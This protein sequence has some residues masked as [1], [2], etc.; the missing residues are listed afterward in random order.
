MQGATVF[1]LAPDARNLDRAR[2]LLQDAAGAL[3]GL[4]SYDRRRDSSDRMRRLRRNVGMVDRLLQSAAAFH[5][6][7]S[8]A[9]SRLNAGYA[10]GGRMTPPSLTSRVSVDC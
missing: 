10:A 2:A 6:G 7:A 5:G 4:K 9:V 1:L 3:V 8:I